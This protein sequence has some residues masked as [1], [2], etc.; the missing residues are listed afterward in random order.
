MAPRNNNNNTTTTKSMRLFAA[1]SALAVLLASSSLP[2]M[3][4]AA[5]VG[6]VPSLDRAG[7]ELADAVKAGGSIA[8]TVVPFA[9]ATAKKV[10]I[11]HKLLVKRLDTL[12]GLVGDV[13]TLSTSLTGAAANAGA[14][15]TN[16]ALSAAVGGVQAKAGLVEAAAAALAG[17][18]GKVTANAAHVGMTALSPLL[19]LHPAVLMIDALD[20]HLRALTAFLGGVADESSGGALAALKPA[21][22][23]MRLLRGKLTAMK[24]L[25]TLSSP[26]LLGGLGLGIDAID[27]LGFLGGLGGLGGVGGGLPGG[28]GGLPGGIGGLANVLPGGNSM[29]GFVKTLDN[30]AGM[31]AKVINRLA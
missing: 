25:L 6:I 24:K 11:A 7:K 17:E 26:N 28:I 4:A 29:V 30:A 21:V 23:V 1:A 5:D 27:A 8:G 19:Q 22:G 12:R 16:A 31:L 20:G 13:V 14:A 2:A 9:G 18:A 15:A 3:A 10:D